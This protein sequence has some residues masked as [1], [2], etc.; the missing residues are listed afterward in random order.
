MNFKNYFIIDR[1]KLDKRIEMLREIIA[2]TELPNNSGLEKSSLNTLLS[3]KQELSTLSLDIGGD[4]QKELEEENTK[5]K[6]ELEETKNLLKAN[7]EECKEIF[8]ENY[9]EN[10]WSVEKFLNKK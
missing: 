6:A 3:I 8:G 10:Y 1:E 4:A 7:H 9:S 2:T 5:L